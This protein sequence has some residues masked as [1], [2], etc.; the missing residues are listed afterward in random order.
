MYPDIINHFKRYASI[1][2]ADGEAFFSIAK[3]RKVAKNKHLIRAGEHPVYMVL[4]LSGCLM[5]YHTAEDGTFN[6]LQ[7]GVKYWWTGDL[8]GF[9]NKKPSGH[10]IRAMSDA[11]VLL[12]EYSQFEALCEE[13]IIFERLF[14]KIFQNSLITH[15]KRIIRNLSMP[16]M[17]RYEWF[18][19][20]FSGLELYVP[21]KYV[22]SY[23]G[24]TPEFLS[25]LR[26]TQ[27]EKK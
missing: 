10:S 12:I 15:S 11:E 8:E 27:A 17:E 3:S 5:T 19:E 24:I 18:Q 13:R 26:R 23:L 1:T 9:T 22:A 21:Q 6:V 2:E 14:R 7:F 16:A 4:V 25:K 20:N